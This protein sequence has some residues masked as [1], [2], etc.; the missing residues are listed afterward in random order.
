MSRVPDSQGYRPS[1][2]PS[3]RPSDPASHPASAEQAFMLMPCRGRF[4]APS[5]AGQEGE[6][7]EETSRAPMKITA[8]WSASVS[9][10]IHYVLGPVCGPDGLCLLTGA[11]GAVC[12]VVI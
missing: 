3:R 9:N 10:S 6:G 4:R 8:F 11:A 7:A 5:V 2:Q 12:A 1:Q